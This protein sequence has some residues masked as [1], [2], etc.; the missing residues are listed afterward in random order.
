MRV[1]VGYDEQNRPYFKSGRNIYQGQTA[2]NDPA[3]R[4]F[5]TLA[6]WPAGVIAYKIRLTDAKTKRIRRNATKNVDVILNF[7]LANPSDVGDL[8]GLT[9]MEVEATVRYAR[10]AVNTFNEAKAALEDCQGLFLRMKYEDGCDGFDSQI[11][12]NKAA[13][14]RMS[15]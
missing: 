1:L 13:L 11:K 12:R 14:A 6:A 5:C 15:G 4:W 3:I 2:E 7:V 8:G 10:R 9:I